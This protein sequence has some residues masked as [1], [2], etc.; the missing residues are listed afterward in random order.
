MCKI[1]VGG[2]R[3]QDLR[4]KISAPGCCR[5]ICARSGQRDRRT[6]CARIFY[7]DLLCKMSVSGPLHQNLLKFMKDV[8]LMHSLRLSFDRR[9]SGLEHTHGRERRIGLCSCCNMA[10]ELCPILVTII[11]WCHGR[12][13]H[14]QDLDLEAWQPWMSKCDEVAF[15]DPST[16]GAGGPPWKAR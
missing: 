11:L 2:S 7:Q 12:L 4:L 16:S 5:T 13:L 3:G 9:L 15:H 8:H 6:T 10:A 1:S 14:V